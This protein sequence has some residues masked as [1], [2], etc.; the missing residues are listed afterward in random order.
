MR[1][2]AWGC[3]EA[4][5]LSHSA[6]P[7]HLVM[8][9]ASQEPDPISCKQQAKNIRATAQKE[10]VSSPD[11]E[12]RGTN[13]CQKFQNLGTFPRLQPFAKLQCRCS[14][15]SGV[16]LNKSKS[17]GCMV[18]PPHAVLCRDG[19]QGMGITALRALAH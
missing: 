3:V 11:W 15:P 18:W 19:N 10:G 7:Q 1:V 12:S 13:C 8:C 14:F 16:L 2:R 9:F 5:T 17:K 4:V 6:T